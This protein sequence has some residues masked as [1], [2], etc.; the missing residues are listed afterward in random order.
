[1]NK[2]LVLLGVALLLT[3]G[4]S[5]QKRVT[6]R[7]VDAD[8]EPLIG[9][10]VRVEG[11]KGVAVTDADG[12]FTLTNV[13]ASSKRLKIT[14]IGKI[15]K[16]VSI[17]GNINVVL[18][19]DENAFD[20]AVVIGY[21]TA[22]KLGTVVGAVKK[23]GSEKINGNPVSN[24]A[25]ALQGQVA[26][27]QVLN[28][29]GDVGDINETPT[30]NVRGVGSLGASNTP[31]IIVDGSP[32]DISVL[33]MLNDKD[34]ESVTTL[35]DASATSIYGSRAANGVL[36]ITTKKGRRGEKGQVTVSQKIGWS[37]LANGIGNPMNAT[38]LLDFQLE[39]GIIS[40]AQYAAYK[41]HGANTDWQKYNFDNAAPMYSTDISIRGGGES[42][43]Y[44]LSGSYLKQAGLTE[45]THFKRYTLR[46]NL[47]AQP[48]KW[49][50]VGLNQNVTYTDRLSDGYTYDGA[51][52]I[53]SFTASSYMFA[54]YWDP[55]DP[56]YAA[57][58]LIYGI[59]DYDTKY[60]ASLQ[61]AQYND[62]VYNGTGYL[63]INPFKGL[64]VRSQLGL[65]ATDT[66]STFKI[67]P[68]FPIPGSAMT[69]ES[70]SRSSMWT[71][72][73]TAEYK[74]NIG[75]RHAVTLL[76]GQE[77]I[78]FTSNV[79]SA[80]TTG[81]TDDRLT[82]LNNGTTPVLPTSSYAKYEYL[83]FFGRADYGYAD[84]YFANI[85][86]RNDASSRFGRD[87]RSATFVSGGVLW[88]MTGE[89]FMTPLRQ[90]FTD[91][92]LK[93]SVGSTGNSEIGNYRHLGITSST[94]YN[95][96][97]GWVLG[98]ASN[99]QLGWEKQIQTNIG[100]E[101][102]IMERLHLDFNWYSRKTK[103]MLMSMPLPYTTGFSSQTMNI[104]EMTNRGVEIEA[105][106]DAIKTRDAYLSV[107]VT[108]GYNTNKIDKLF[109]GLDEWP[110]MGALVNYTVGSSINYYMPIF[111]GV[112][113]EDGAPMWYKVGYKGDPVHE[114]NPETMTK[115]ASK[116]DDLYQD[117]GK[118]RFAPHNG[119]FGLTAAWKGLTLSADFSFVLGKWMVNNDYYLA[120]SKGNAI[121]ANNQDKDMLN[122]WKKP[123]DLTFIPSLNYETQFDSHL[124]ENAS[125][126]RLKHLSLSYDLP[127]PWMEATR[128]L[129]NVRLNFTA[130]NVFTITRYRGVDPEIDT[131]LT[132]N[133]YPATRQFTL[134]LEVTF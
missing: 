67:L 46:S 48:L 88:N 24:V 58:H 80:R 68:S 50:S 41:A 81:Q 1:M 4:V 132:Y 60:L 70:S 77:G 16:T 15:A 9:A 35:K 130:R 114:F 33:N 113:K 107:R 72:T 118:K 19:D 76:A 83:S 29:T 51:P 71:I 102:T 101:A 87:N 85:T 59:N 8:G 108:Y 10:S 94:Q 38:E 21:G 56:D 43:S 5:A 61:P 128:C 6:G 73:N 65:Y 78:K 110:V 104:G 7:V 20:E 120:A 3:A 52:S 95:G 14:S 31:L 69:N 63:Q 109:Y 25:D 96:Q 13:P 115:D 23:V 40:G 53:R 90:W 100:L 122:A 117:T 27:M 22:Q 26:G 12:R 86:V 125:F 99:T 97:S 91:L 119:G 34:I 89:A 124:L 111:A 42:S 103:D 75:E 64:T 123:G 17:A 11:G 116:I 62:I 74:F 39:N 126:L 32:A 121:Y 79:F 18:Q 57:Q 66:R 37:Q 112:D 127:K 45:S 28:N 93:A 49:L 134:G 2:K 82:T 106:F 105:Q 84:K 92:R 44:L 133:S 36:Y 54:P 55:Y 129:S 30:I 131:N 98:Q 47:D